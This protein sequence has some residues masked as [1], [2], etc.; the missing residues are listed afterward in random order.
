MSDRY[1]TLR[2]AALAEYRDKGSKFLGFA[3]PAPD[4]AAVE[5]SLTALRALHPKATH[6]CYAYRLGKQGVHYRANDDG[7]PAGSAGRPILNQIDSHGLN[8]VL[9]VVV[10]Y[11]GGTKLGVPGL[12]SAYKETARLTLEN[13]EIVEGVYLASG[14]VEADYQALPEVMNT[15]KRHQW[16]ITESEYLPSGQLIHFQVPESDWQALVEDLLTN[17]GGLYPDEIKAGKTS[18]LLKIHR[19]DDDA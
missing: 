2:A 6:H 19:I 16:V 11:F 5:A 15:G 13:A 14:S 10:R 7:E 8:H 12:I 1:P 18:N 17:A 9:V 3:Y 4:M